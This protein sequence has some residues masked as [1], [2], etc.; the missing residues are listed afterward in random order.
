MAM[1]A[2]S[3][4]GAHSNVSHPGEMLLCAV[5]AIPSQKGGGGFGG[6][7]YEVHSGAAE[8]IICEE[9]LDKPGSFTLEHQK[10]RE[11]LMEVCKM[12][13]GKDRVGLAKGGKV[14]GYRTKVESLKGLFF[15]GWRV[16]G[17]F[18]LGCWWKQI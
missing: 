10:L 6:G 5:L 3:N 4:P 17:A 13:R 14:K 18:C 11:D 16:T 1:G 12:V 2:R 7:A 15:R 8:G 9:R